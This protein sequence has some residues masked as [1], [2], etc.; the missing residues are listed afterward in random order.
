MNAPAL[1]V[2]IGTMD[3]RTYI[4]GSDIAAIM[5]LSPWKTPLQL[6]EEKVATE[7]PPPIDEEKRRFF[8]RRKRQEPVVAEMLYDT[9]GIEVTRL[10]LD[11]NPNRYIDGEH[12]FMAAEIDFEFLMTDIVRDAFFDRP[13]FGAIPN[14]TLLNGEIKTVHPFK[15]QEWGEEGSESVPVHY[16]AQ[17]LYG[18]GITHRPAT[19]VAALFGLDSLVLFPLMADA[20]TIAGMRQKAVTFWVQHVLAKIAPDPINMEDMMRLFARVNGKPVEADEGTIQML[21]D[22]R[23]IRSS[24]AA[25]ADEKEELEFK[26]ADFVRRQW[27][28][29]PDLDAQAI[30]NAI[31]TLGGAPYATWKKQSRSSIDSKR[32]RADEPI[33]AANYTQT[34]FF[35]SIRFPKQK[36]A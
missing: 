15:A 17:S 26:V 34:S 2:A 25:M 32:L 35:R 27:G 14:G 36:G 21:D 31:I 29:A 16:A 23:R 28:V 30:D 7:P 18:L 13:D 24:I 10:S 22:L 1:P 9:Y 11:D 4:G 33:I 5:G 12:P 6:Y 20:E 8:A 3:R 19:L